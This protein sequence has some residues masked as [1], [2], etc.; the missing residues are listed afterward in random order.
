VDTWV[1]DQ[2]CLELGDIDVEGTI[3][4]EGGGQGGDNL[5]DEAVQVGVGWALDVEVAAAD[6]VDGLVIKDDCNIGVLQQ[7]VGGEDGVVGLNNG[8]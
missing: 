7:R 5:S 6:V 8:S 1:G 3:E 2:V 4:S